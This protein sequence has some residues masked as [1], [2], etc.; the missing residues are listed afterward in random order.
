MPAK[1]RGYAEIDRIRSESCRCPRGLLA[2][3]QRHRG[4]QEGE[5][6]PNS[7]WTAGYLKSSHWCKRIG[8]RSRD[9][10]Q[11]PSRLRNVAAKRELRERRR[12]CGNREEPLRNPLPTRNPRTYEAQQTGFGRAER[13]FTL[14]E[15]IFGFRL[16]G[17]C[18][19]W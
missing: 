16:A 2:G 12:L 18:E 6:G 11:Q 19:P 8:A 10:R 9:I 14:S 13:Y 4:R 17:L 5:P 7:S 15:A 3:R 1:S